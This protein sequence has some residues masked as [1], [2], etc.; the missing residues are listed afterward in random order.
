MLYIPDVKIKIQASL[1]RD[2]NK[3]DRQTKEK[4]QPMSAT[5]CYCVRQFCRSFELVRRNV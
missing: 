4:Q 2:A 3:G 1:P 5:E